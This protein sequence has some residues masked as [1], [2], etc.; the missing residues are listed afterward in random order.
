MEIIA[1]IVEQQPLRTEEY[2]DRQGQ[3]QSLTKMGFKLATGGH[4]YYAEVVGEAATRIPTLDRSVYYLVNLNLRRS[5]WV[6]QDGRTRYSNDLRINSIH[7][8]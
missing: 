4:N 2:K 8:L 7:P 5:D 6:G 1:R 3:K